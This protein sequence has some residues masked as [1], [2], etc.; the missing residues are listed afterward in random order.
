MTTFNLADLFESVV[1]TAGDR[2]ALVTP[3][4]RLTYTELD[5]RATRLAHHLADAGIGAGDHIGLHLMNGTEYVEGMLAA[6]KIRAVPV[7][8]NYRY[9]ERELQHLYS[10]MDLEATVV[11]RQFAPLV[12]AI[13]AEVPTLRHVLVVDDH[14]QAPDLEGS[15]PYEEALAAASAAREFGPRSSDDTYVACTGGT[16]GLP[17]G[18]LWRHEDIFFASLGG[19]DPTTME[20]PIS[21]PDQLAGRVPE[22]GL[23]MVVTPPLMHVS[24]HWTTFMT[25]YG[26][27]TVVLPSPGPFDPAEVWRLTADEG[28]NMIV[29]VGNAMA[30]PLL[31]HYEQHPVEAPSLFALASGG[32][33]LSPSVKARAASLVPNLMVI[34]GYGS[35]ETGVAGTAAPD[36]DGGPVFTVSETTNVLDD[37][38]DPI[39]PGSG[40]VGHVARRGSIPI[41]YYKDPEKTAAT[42]KEKN[43]VRWVLS[44]DMGTIEPD[45]T[46]TLLGRGSVSINTG[47]EKVFPEEVESSLIS[48]E[49][50]A[51]V[52]VV[53][54]DDD[55]WG[56]RIVAVVQPTPGAAPK[57]EELAAHA[58]QHLAGYKVPRQVVLVDKVERG[59]NGKA[60]YRWAKERASSAAET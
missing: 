17:K 38:L 60:D 14:S 13:A 15:I 25:L 26:G 19:G 48:H 57:V 53:G 9:V 30:T 32:A 28:A 55:R 24:A 31:D 6:Y 12:D 8:V 46:I 20:G 2:T 35:S 51:D 59:P 33:I 22:I 16:T 56:Q 45:G 21:D 49:A 44:G 10:Y 11:H 34:D 40:I 4:R 23:V 7:N 54:V 27:G 1:D 29:V 36:S 47:G 42:F 58:R 39:E 50:V 52:V 5:Q 18:V 3:A 43:G 37:D 41:G